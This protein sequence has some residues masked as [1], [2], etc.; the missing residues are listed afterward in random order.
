MGKFS[1]SIG[2]T[3]PDGLQLGAGQDIR[4]VGPLAVGNSVFVTQKILLCANVCP[5][6][7]HRHA[8]DGLP[9][10]FQMGVLFP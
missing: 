10:T 4:A 2:I 9:E 1:F 3:R 8:R 5:G 7:G 6:F